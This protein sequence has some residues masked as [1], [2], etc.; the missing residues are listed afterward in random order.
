M[1]L[2][3]TP[4]IDSLKGKFTFIDNEMIDAVHRTGLFGIFSRHGVGK[5][6]GHGIPQLVFA[7]LVWPFLGVGSI[8]S[9]CG[10]MVEHFLGGGKDALYRFLRREDI[11]WRNIALGVSRTVYDRHGLGGESAF[12]VDDTLKHR[13]GKKVEGVSSHFDHTECR[14]VS[15]QQVVQLGLAGSKGFLPLLQQIY[16]G[17]KKVQ[18]VR[19]EFADG[20]SAVAKD[21][22]TAMHK[23]KNQMLR[24]MLRRAVRRGFRAAHLL[25][26]TWFGNKGNIRTALELGLVAI[27][28]MKRGN[29]AYR[30]QGRCYTAAMLHELVKRRM[31]ARRGCCFLT[32]SLIVGINL[33]GPGESDEWVRVRL[34]FSKPRR[35]NKGAWVVLLCTDTGYT[36]ERILE[37]YAL[38]W[39]IE[40]YFKEVKQ[41]MG[42]LAEQS[43]SYA[44]HYASIHLA[45]I[46]YML[47]FSLALDGGG[48]RFGQV[49]DRV[50]RTLQDIGFSALLWEFFKAL[51]RGVLESFRKMIGSEA[52]DMILKAMDASVEE[53]LSRVLQIDPDSILLQQKAEE[54]GVL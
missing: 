1:K 27:F 43:G 34:L 28:M 33:A 12:V 51:L 13:R 48:V 2:E 23:D 9:F 17:K 49:R 44:V 39:G 42:W 30:F 35:E 50:S 5:R 7:L 11:N 21:Y 52:A 53:F 38:R 40:V 15:G 6:S 31:K 8:A 54:L 22:A 32:H 46:R 19:K 4:I 36:D 20:R 3:P 41:A 37:T 26:D 16:I 47:L 10:R 45:A 25:G 24:E 14:H 29:L 18:P